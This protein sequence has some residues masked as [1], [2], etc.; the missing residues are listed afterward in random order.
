MRHAGIRRNSGDAFGHGT[1][2]GFRL[3]DAGAGNEKERIASTK[4]QRAEC[5]L[6]RVAHL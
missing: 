2:V 3:N 1:G 5:Y 4:A 6:A